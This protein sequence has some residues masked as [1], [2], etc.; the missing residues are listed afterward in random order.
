MI[1]RRGLL[2]MSACLAAIRPAQAQLLRDQPIRLIIPFPAGGPADLIARVISRVMTTKLQ[3][4]IVVDARSGAGGTIGVGA[5]ATAPADGHTIG[6][7]S[8]GAVTILPHLMPNLPYDPLKD[9][10]TIG[11]VLTVPQILAVP[12]T[13]EARS[14]ADLVA[15]A[16]A[17]PGQLAYGSAGI[18]SSLHMAGELFKLA[19]GIDTLHVPYRG[20][21]PAVTDLLGGRIQFM[22]ADV[23]VLLPQIR[24]GTLRALAV[25][26]RTRAEVAP[27]LPTM[28]ESGVDVVSET[29]Y[30]LVA[31]A[32]TP[33]DR[34]ELLAQALA[35]ARRDPETRQQLA[36]QGGAISDLDPAGFAAYIRAE[37]A[38]WGDVVR[39]AGVKM[40]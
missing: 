40:E 37:H 5:V 10:A 18:G 8:T 25:T 26:S 21:A 13:L 38:R 33:K 39:R 24:A 20:A 6:L 36:D 23:P 11:L 17:K 22:L 16:K 30:G 7:A 32:A 9:L 27:D 15:M 35:D 2:A 1:T 29:W 19:A 34:L 4:S 12:T 14:V 31:P 28:L 3:R